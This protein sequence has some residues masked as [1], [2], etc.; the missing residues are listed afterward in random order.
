MESVT[1]VVSDN[2]NKKY[3]YFL[4]ITY[5]SYMKI[6]S[7]H[8]TM[9]FIII[10][11]NIAKKCGLNYFCADSLNWSIVNSMKESSYWIN[12]NK[13]LVRVDKREVSPQLRGR[14]GDGVCGGGGAAD[15]R[16][17]GEALVADSHGLQ[18]AEARQRDGVGTTRCAEH[19]AWNPILCFSSHLHIF[20]M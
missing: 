10:K 8:Y 20:F 4:R 14:R 15:Q 19:F 18:L 2:F 6:A 13:A 7:K 9:Y 17:V 12:V 1:Y 5:F 3:R 16:V 11:S